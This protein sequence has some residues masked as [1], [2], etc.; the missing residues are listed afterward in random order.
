MK[1]ITREPPGCP[2]QAEQLLRLIHSLSAARGQ[3]RRRL[4]ELAAEFDLSDGELLVVWLCGGADRVQGELAAAIGV[5]PAQ[6]SGLAEK[7]G[8]RGLVEMNRPAR[9]RR[10]QVWKTTA[11]GLALLAQAAVPLENLAAA[12]AEHLPPHEQRLAQSLCQR[13]AAAAAEESRP[14]PDEHSVSK[15]AA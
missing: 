12:I 9:D 7:L 6:M 11:A 2:P 1:P 5:S 15:E 13:L 4:S 3:L 14:T 8:Q 10:R